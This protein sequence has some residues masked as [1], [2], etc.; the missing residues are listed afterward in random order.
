MFYRLYDKQTGC[1]M[2]TGYNSKN[3]TE[4]K[5]N[6]LSYIFYD[7]EKEDMKIL[8]KMSIENLSNQLEF[9]IEKQKN[10]FEDNN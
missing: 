6:L 10:K 2:H 7:T 4:L 1:Y 8:E 5:E 3:K 9:T